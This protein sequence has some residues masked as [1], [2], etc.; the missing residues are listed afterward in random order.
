MRDAHRI[1][2]AGTARDHDRPASELSQR[3]LT[4]PEL[5]LPCRHLAL[6]TIVTRDRTGPMIQPRVGFL[7]GLHLRH[8]GY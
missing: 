3:A 8:L 6:R 1:D 4:R 5:T 7:N 2:R